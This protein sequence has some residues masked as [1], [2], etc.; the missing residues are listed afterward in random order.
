MRSVNERGGS[1]SGFWRF[2]AIEK[3]LSFTIGGIPYQAS[4]FSSFTRAFLFHVEAV[5]N[6]IFNSFIFLSCFIP[7]PSSFFLFNCAS[8]QVQS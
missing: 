8:S 2:S 1:D 6:S 3:I 7:S 4:S 5:F